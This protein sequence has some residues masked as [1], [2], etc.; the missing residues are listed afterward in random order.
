MLTDHMHT[1]NANEL[2]SIELKAKINE[3]ASISNTLIVKFSQ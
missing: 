1:P 2:V 3:N